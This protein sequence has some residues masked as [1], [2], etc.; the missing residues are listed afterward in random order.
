MTEETEDQRL[1]RTML[2]ASDTCV[3]ATWEND[4]DTVHTVLLDVSSEQSPLLI[5]L[6]RHWAY[7]L[8]EFS[9]GELPGALVAG[10]VDDFDLELADLVLAGGIDVGDLVAEILSRGTTRDNVTRDATFGTMLAG[11]GED[12]KATTVMHLLGAAAAHDED[13]M[14]ATLAVVDVWDRADQQQLALMLLRMVAQDLPRTVVPSRYVRLMAALTAVMV[15]IDRQDLLDLATPL[16][17]LVALYWARQELEELVLAHATV[18]H[19]GLAFSS[20]PAR[21]TAAMILAR[22]LGRA[23]N[24]GEPVTS[25]HGSVTHSDA[26]TLSPDLDQLATVE[27]ISCRLIARAAAGET[28]TIPDMFGELTGHDEAQELC[29]LMFLTRW[30]AHVT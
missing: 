15:S 6:L 5:L 2:A 27:I 1:L 29:V 16:T 3:T 17:R 14:R 8:G 24:P 9:H 18:S 13:Q 25:T 7:L 19:L 10:P 21:A 4:L 11:H 23:Y 28:A 20:R 30:V 26:S 12:A 22:L